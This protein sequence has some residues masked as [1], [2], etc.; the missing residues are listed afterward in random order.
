MKPLHPL[1]TPFLI[2]ATAATTA[3]AQSANFEILEPSVPT[4]TAIH[5]SAYPLFTNP[6]D[7]F[8]HS[9]AWNFGEQTLVPDPRNYATHKQI[10]IG[11]SFPGPIAAHIY[12]T[13]GPKTITLHDYAL[14]PDGSQGPL[15]RTATATIN[16]L[17]A[18]RHQFYVDSIKGNDKNPGTQSQPLKSADAAFSHLGSNT[19]IDFTSAQTFLFTTQINLGFTNAHLSHFNSGPAPI[20]C[21]T[22]PGNFFSTWNAKDI[23]INGLTF[24]S[25]GP[26]QILGIFRGQNITFTD[27]NF[28]N[29]AQAIQGS[30][31]LNGMFIQRCK[32]LP[33]FN[34][35]SRC[36]WIEGN[37]WISAG[38]TYFNSTAESPVRMD[39]GSPTSPGGVNV[40][41]TANRVGQLL[42]PTRKMAKAALTFRDG[43]NIFES[44]C[45]I[46]DAENSINTP[47]WPN[48]I[49][50]IDIRNNV[51][52][53]TSQSDGDAKMCFYTG[54]KS[55]ALQ[56]NTVFTKQGP[57]YTI[58]TL[59]P[60]PKLNDTGVIFRNNTATGWSPNSRL[61]TISN[62]TGLIINSNNTATTKPTTPTL[63]AT[64]PNN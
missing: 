48:T 57:A 58:Q 18:N 9:L 23:A 32:Q 2:A 12:Y 7:T 42:S 14:N 30:D 3:R 22:T 54:I 61:A 51:L 25:S 60:N 10:D 26:Q 19:E 55:G 13:P 39:S 6:S 15:L 44:N 37:N 40:S 28:A 49:N 4:G 35:S 16:V 63:P 5:V 29:L 33:P 45:L 38:N 27:C 8:N 50:N 43:Q 62:P 20:L 47:G 52:I 31:N 17:P 1:L 24:T 21:K 11:Q 59:D 53:G 41:F 56:N 36:E 46:I 64:M 34:M